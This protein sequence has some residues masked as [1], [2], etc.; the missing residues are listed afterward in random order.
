MHML[1]SLCKQYVLMDSK[2]ENLR[3]QIP[4]LALNIPAANE[5]VGDVERCIRVIKERSRGLIC[6]LPYSKIPQTM[7]INLLHF[8]VM[9]LNN[10]P[11]LDSISVDYSPRELIL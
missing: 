5:H 3:D 11:T 2:F 4:M 9:W 1:V 7:L 10:F 6:T 8:M